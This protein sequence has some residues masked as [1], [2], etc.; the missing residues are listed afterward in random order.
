[1]TINKYTDKMH[2]LSE[3]ESEIFVRGINKETERYS[4]VY[5]IFNRKYKIWINKSGSVIFSNG[6][7]RVDIDS[8][9]QDSTQEE[10]DFLIFNMD[11]FK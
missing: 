8:V 6:L 5:W 7:R 4:G 1:M 10:Q 9:L 3:I 2:K 11:L